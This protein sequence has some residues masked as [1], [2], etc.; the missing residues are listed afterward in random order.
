MTEQYY[1]TGRRK[2]ST[3]RVFLRPNSSK[4]GT[5]VVNN[6][7]QEQYFSRRSALILVNQPL[8]IAD[9]PAQ[10][11][12][13]LITVKGGGES[14]QAGA[15][16]LGLARAL[17]QYDEQ[18]RKKMRLEDYLTRDPRKVE[19]KKVGRPKARRRKQF[20]KR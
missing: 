17:V 16:R 1:G 2:T 6:Q 14:G 8:T 20:S 12:D 15:I 18:L 19:R 13:I 10:N 4:K 9:L 3:A 7:P 11:F 5:F